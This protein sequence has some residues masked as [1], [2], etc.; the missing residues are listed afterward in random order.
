MSSYTGISVASSLGDISVT[1]LSG[2]VELAAQQQFPLE[3]FCNYQGWNQ[4]GLVVQVPQDPNVTM[5]TVAQTHATTPVD[6]S[7]TFDMSNA[8]ITISMKAVDV[9]VYTHSLIAAGNAPEPLIKDSMT[10]A[11]I[12]NRASNFMALYTAA[13]TANVV[14][15]SGTAIS[16]DGSFLTALQLLATNAA[17]GDLFWILAS[18]QI[19]EFG[20]DTHFKNWH[21]SG[22]QLL[23]QNIVLPSGFLGVSPAGVEVYWNNHYTASSGNH[24]MMFSKNA[25][26]CYDQVPLKI[27]MDMSEMWVRDRVVR[28]GATT[29]YGLGS[30]RD[31]GSTGTNL[32]ICDVVS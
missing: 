28:I 2:D 18:T 4:P 19:S 6:A 22:L 20:R 14:G 10:K 12:R 26:R 1:V 11:Y 23:A 15:E 16:H 31:G 24:G 25:I 3:R 9:N 29:M 8:Q 13:P 21:A 7:N 17:E 5:N 30:A 27:E 32:W